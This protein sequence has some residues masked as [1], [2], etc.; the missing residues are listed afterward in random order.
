MLTRNHYFNA[1]STLCLTFLLAPIQVPSSLTAAINLGSLPVDEARY[2][3]IFKLSPPRLKDA[4]TH[5]KNLANLKTLRC[6][7]FSTA[8]CYSL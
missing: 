7:L 2:T 5:P 4:K 1:K 8:P 3:V 6:Y